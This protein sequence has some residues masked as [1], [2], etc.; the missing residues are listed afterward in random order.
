MSIASHALLIGSD[1][2]PLAGDDAVAAA[3]ELIRHLG[4]EDVVEGGRLIAL[5]KV[6]EEV[7]DLTEELAYTLS[8]SSKRY[9]Y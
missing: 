2:H 5:N 3:V 7:G 6:G 9:A 4:G 8:H 1:L